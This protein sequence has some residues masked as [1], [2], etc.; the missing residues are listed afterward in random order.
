MEV[1]LNNL[2][3]PGKTRVITDDNRSWVLNLACTKPSYYG[4]P[5]ELWS[6]TIMTDHLR[7]NS[8]SLGSISR[9]TVFEILN[10]SENKP[11]RVRYYV[12]KK[13]LDFEAKMAVVLHV[14]RD[15]DMINNGVIIPELRDTG[16]SSFVEK[17]RMQAISQTSNEPPTVPGKR[18]SVTRDYEY[19]RLGTLSLLAGIDLH[20]GTVTKT[21]NKT[22]NSDDFISF[23]K[24]LDTSI[25]VKK[26]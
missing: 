11:H 1:A 22:H 5:D 9:S 3:R 8:P 26:G 19:K 18:P 21:V 14:Y 7:K 12:E 2:P 20:S 16:A 13:D 15:I 25:P 10:D 6:Y 24:R 23:L 17:P 4:Y